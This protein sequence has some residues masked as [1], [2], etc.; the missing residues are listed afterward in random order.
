MYTPLYDTDVYVLRQLTL[1]DLLLTFATNKYIKYQNDPIILKKLQ[2]SEKRAKN[3][4]DVLKTRTAPVFINF[5]N[6]NE[7]IRV[8]NNIMNGILIQF[9]DPVGNGPRNDDI[10]YN[11]SITKVNDIGVRI[12]FYGSVS[13]IVLNYSQ[14]QKLLK[15][16]FYDDLILKI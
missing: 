8:I 10:M 1:K 12:N 7:E 4:I 14:T 16:L 6:E 13:T 3:I 9:D 11:M 2:K 15:H 5:K